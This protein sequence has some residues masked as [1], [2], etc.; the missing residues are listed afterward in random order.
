MDTTHNSDLSHFSY[1]GRDFA[2]LSQ[3]PAASGGLDMRKQKMLAKLLQGRKEEPTQTVGG[4]AVPQSGIQ[5]LNNALSG[6]PDMMMMSKKPPMF[7][8]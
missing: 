3:A 2:D 8:G 6:L 1:Q 5:G 4:W 7:G